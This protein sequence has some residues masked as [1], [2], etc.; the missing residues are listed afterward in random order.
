VEIKGQIFI[1]DHKKRVPSPGPIYT[2]L[3]I[4]EGQYSTPVSSK[5]AKKY[6]K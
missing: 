3:K 4:T 6:A 2:E 1:C 5:S